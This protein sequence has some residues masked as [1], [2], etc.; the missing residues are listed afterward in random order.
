MQPA[1]PALT[2]LEVPMSR[3]NNPYLSST[4]VVTGMGEKQS[5]LSIVRQWLCVGAVSDSY[6]NL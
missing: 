5:V 3:K 4:P 2:I 1:T 6:S